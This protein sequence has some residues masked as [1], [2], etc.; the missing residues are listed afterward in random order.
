MSTALTPF[1]GDI[2]AKVL[3]G[4]AVLGAA[5][6]AALVASLA[7]AW[8]MSE[9]FGWAHT[10]NERPNGMVNLYVTYA[11]AHVLGAAI[12]L[13]SVHLVSLVIDVE[14]M[15]AWIIPIMLGFLLG[16]RDQGVAGGLP[17]ARRLPGSRHRA[18][19]G[20]DGLRPLHSARHS[21]MGVKPR[22]RLRSIVMTVTVGEWTE[23]FATGSA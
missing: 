22:R 13:V 5:M 6:V 23:Q 7:G 1:L 14:V 20:G 16:A 3:L 21:G 4:V 15:N 12:V 8:G 19:P 18:V 17:D 11:L 2:G 9:V 10:L